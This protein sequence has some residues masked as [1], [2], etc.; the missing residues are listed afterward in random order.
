MQECGWNCTE[1]APPAQ[2]LWCS[3]AGKWANH[4]G[5]Q[6]DLHWH[7][8]SEG[9]QPGMDDEVWPR[10]VKGK[11]GGGT[12]PAMDA[13]DLLWHVCVHGAVGDAIRPIRWV[14]DA[15]TILQSRP[16]AIDWERLVTIA[17]RRH[18]TLVI[19]RALSLLREEFN[20]PIPP[21]V[22]EQ[23]RA[24]PNGWLE[25]W[26]TRI[27][28]GPPGIS[29]ALP[30]HLVNYLR[31]TRRENLW[32]KL[33]GLPPFFQRVWGLPNARGLPAYVVKKAATRLTLTK[34]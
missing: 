1:S 27:K 18:L 20:A 14:A 12:F 31:L 24:T 28:A 34:N 7:V 25:R 29:G 32:R 6:I 15:W 23:L 17:Q 22:I 2:L 13:T 4:S 9:R 10:A 33:T 21:P 26:E 8:L 30:L 5:Q 11:I 3:Y 19:G 16:G